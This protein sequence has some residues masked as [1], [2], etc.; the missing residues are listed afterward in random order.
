M[1]EVMWFHKVANDKRGKLSISQ[2]AMVAARI[3]LLLKEAA[4]CSSMK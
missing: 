2:R 1:Q 4:K 3:K